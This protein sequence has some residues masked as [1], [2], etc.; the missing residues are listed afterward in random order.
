MSSKTELSDWC[1]LYKMVHATWEEVVM[2]AAP[3]LGLSVEQF[4]ALY[5]S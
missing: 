2:T 3:R 5:V 4:Q 1:A